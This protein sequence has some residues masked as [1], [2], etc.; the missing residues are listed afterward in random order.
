MRWKSTRNI[1]RNLTVYRSLHK[2]QF[3]RSLRRSDKDCHPHSLYKFTSETDL[4]SPMCCLQ[5]RLQIFV[6][7]LGFKVTLKDTSNLFYGWKQ[8]FD[9]GASYFELWLPISYLSQMSRSNIWAEPCDNVSLGDLLRH[10]IWRRKVWRI[11]SAPCVI[12]VSVKDYSN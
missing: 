12:K 6:M 7:T 5:W 1:Y 9:T 11:F 2:I 10:E 4:V 3:C 8:C